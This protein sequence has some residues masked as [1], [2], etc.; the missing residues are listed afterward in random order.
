MIR[1]WSGI[2]SAVLLLLFLAVVYLE[3]TPEWKTHQRRFNRMEVEQLVMA[4]QRAEK[5]LEGAEARQ[6][7]QALEEARARLRVNFEKP[8]VQQL[9]HQSK[10]ALRDLEA[11]LEKAQDRLQKSRAD[12]QA[13]E[14]AYILVSEEP[15]LSELRKKM[16]AARVVVA[17]AVAARDDWKRQVDVQAAKVASSTAELDAVKQKLA[18]VTAERKKLAADLAKIRS[19][20]PEIKQILLSE[21][22]QADRCTTCHVGTIRNLF[23]AGP[24]SLRRHP[25]FYL[26]D[27]PPERFGCGPCHGG[28]PRATVARA[29]HG[30]T[31]HWPVPLIPTE[32]LGGACG[33]CHREEELPFEPQLNDGRKLFAEAGC[34]ACHDVE[35]LRPAEKLGPDLSRI[36]NK[37]YPQWL[38]RWLKNPRDYLPRT[39]MPNF[40]LTEEEIASI[41]SFLLSL[42][43]SAPAAG[44]SANRTSSARCEPVS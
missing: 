21:W 7:L 26:E 28:Q 14:R 38:R 17:Q 40:L 9:Y 44:H 32:F 2:S 5:R 24:P 33:K 36:G 18:Q 35:G 43:D 20:R 12:Y 34:V 8:E 16:E 13:L 22:N 6:Q 10:T 29:A 41:Q 25:G 27:H 42:P 15:R 37:V 4:F 39:R 30:Q 11:H 3:V 19:W 23:R 1:L 31:A